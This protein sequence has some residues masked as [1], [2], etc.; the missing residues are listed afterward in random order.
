MAVDADMVGE[1]RWDI[2]RRLRF[3]ITHMVAAYVGVMSMFAL[4]FFIGEEIRLYPV[5]M[6]NKHMLTD[7]KK[8]YSFELE[9]KWTVK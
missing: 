8:H 7:G 4:L 3:P 6:M 5:K 2:S 1:D 9:D